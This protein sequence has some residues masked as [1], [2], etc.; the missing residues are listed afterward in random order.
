L[1]TSGNEGQVQNSYD[2]QR[3]NLQFYTNTG[4]EEGARLEKHLEINGFEN[5][6]KIFTQLNLG[7][8]PVFRDLKAAISGGLVSGD[9]WQDTDGNLKII[10]GEQDEEQRAKG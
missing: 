2:D 8:V 10:F 5:K 4:N 9:V 3:A 6:T 1:I 7:K